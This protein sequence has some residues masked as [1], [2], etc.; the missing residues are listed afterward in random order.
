VRRET[1]ET[2]EK[3]ET[4]ERIEH[5]PSGPAHRK[6]LKTQKFE[7]ALGVACAFRSQ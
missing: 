1:D 3:D 6:M 4:K 7:K 2:T 5:R